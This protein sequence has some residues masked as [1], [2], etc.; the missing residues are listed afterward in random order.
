MPY[1]FNIFI[2]IKLI[3]NNKALIIITF[4]ILLLSYKEVNMFYKVNIFYKVDVPYKE[5][6]FYRVNMSN[7]EVETFY[8]KVDVII[9]N[10]IYIIFYK[11]S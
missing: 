9:I 8:K 6:I 11:L 1:I 5:V 4:V 3:L 7:K 10:I 2:A